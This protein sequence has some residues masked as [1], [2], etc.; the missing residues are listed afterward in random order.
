MFMVLF[1][2]TLVSNRIVMQGLS[3]RRRELISFSLPTLFNPLTF[4]ATIM[5][6]S[7]DSLEGHS[8]PPLAQQNH[9]D[10]QPSVMFLL[11]TYSY[12]YVFHYYS[13]LS[14][15]HGKPHLLFLCLCL[16]SPLVGSLLVVPCSQH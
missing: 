1:F 8:K 10:I 9:S 11:A 12:L 2:F 5:V 4:Q 3:C 7:F 16:C 6:H 15:S 13:S 14:R